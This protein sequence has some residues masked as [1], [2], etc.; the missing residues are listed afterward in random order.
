MDFKNKATK[1]CTGLKLLADS[2]HSHL[3]FVVHVQVKARSVH[4]LTGMQLG[5]IAQQATQ[6]SLK[7]LQDFK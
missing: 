4:M 7:S 2:E 1:L 6:S 5:N 3:G